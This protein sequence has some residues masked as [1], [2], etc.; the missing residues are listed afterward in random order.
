MCNAT[1][2][3]PW[4]AVQG[5]IASTQQCGVFTE[6]APYPPVSAKINKRKQCYR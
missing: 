1:K 5:K 3:M 6:S 4:V 2:I